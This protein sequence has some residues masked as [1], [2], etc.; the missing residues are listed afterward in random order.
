[1]FRGEL[2]DKGNVV[3]EGMKPLAGDEITAAF[4]KRDRKVLKLPR[5]ITEIEWEKITYL[6][7]LHPDGSKWFVVYNPL[8]ELHGLVL[9]KMETTG[10][11]AKQCSWC[12]TTNAGD[13]IAQFVVRHALNR[14]ITMGTY[15][16]SSLDCD[17]YIR[18][19]KFPSIATFSSY[20]TLEKR[21]KNLRDN[22]DN[23]FI[24]A[25]F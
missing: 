2:G 16:C 15:V 9:E 7:W 25:L 21:V 1:M 18:G 5:N 4:S 23:F 10:S 19:R 6:S 12:A 17:D 8:D 24:R 3:A 20:P 11:S 13:R 14:S 22:L